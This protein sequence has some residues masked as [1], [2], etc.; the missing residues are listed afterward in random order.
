MFNV[1]KVLKIMIKIL[2]LIFEIIKRDRI[3]VMKI[4]DVL[5]FF[6]IVIKKKIGILIVMIFFRSCLFE[7]YLLD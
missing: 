6:C 7:C 1:V 3:I 5:K 2:W 4:R